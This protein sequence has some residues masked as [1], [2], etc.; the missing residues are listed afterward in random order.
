MPQMDFSLFLELPIFFYSIF[1][2][3]LGQ[4]IILAINK[5]SLIFKLRHFYIQR[6]S[7]FK[8]KLLLE[9]QLIKLK[10]TLLYR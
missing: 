7:F 4:Q 6:Y 2:F 9:I 8:M 3:V 10:F 5:F 1:L